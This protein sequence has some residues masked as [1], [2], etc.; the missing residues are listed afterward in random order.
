M[1]LVPVYCHSTTAG[2]YEMSDPRLCGSR[3]Y[4]TRAL[5]SSTHAMCASAETVWK[6][7][8]TSP[9]RR[10]ERMSRTGPSG[11][12]FFF[13]S[14][15][16]D[17]DWNVDSMLTSSA[18]AQKRNQ[19]RAAEERAAPAAPGAGCFSMA[20][21]TATW[22]QPTVRIFSRTFFS[23][24]RLGGSSIWYSGSGSAGSQTMSA[25]GSGSTRTGTSCSTRWSATLPVSEKSKPRMGRPSRPLASRRVV[26]S[27]E[28]QL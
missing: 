6:A 4:N 15:T 20:A 26:R 19:A 16:S 8:S 11:E 22:W 1:M 14:V 13:P 18:S 9:K 27:L 28:A 2:V 3:A 12:A 21:S 10:R 17:R 25:S 24:C 7:A 23:L 5:S